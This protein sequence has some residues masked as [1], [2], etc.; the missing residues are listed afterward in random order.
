[1]PVVLR[2]ALLLVDEAGRVLLRGICESSVA[3][4]HVF[5]VLGGRLALASLGADATSSGLGDL[6]SGHGALPGLALLRGD[7][8]G[9]L[10]RRELLLDLAVA[11][12]WSQSCQFS[13]RF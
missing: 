7:G 3:L 11:S 9:G 4:Q 13:P 10:V 12:L 8:G 2:P 6:G 1:M 5:V